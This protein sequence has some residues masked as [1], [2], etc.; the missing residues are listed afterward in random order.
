MNRDLAALGDRELEMALREV[1]RGIE[2]PR[3]ADPWA[4]IERA[5][6]DDTRRPVPLLRRWAAHPVAVAAT[7]ILTAVVAVAAIPET[8]SAVADWLGIGGVRIQFRERLPE[9]GR[10]LALG[11]EV[12]ASVAEERAGFEVR[13]PADSL[14]S[15]DTIFL[16]DDAAGPRV[17][18]VYES[19]PGLPEAGTTGLG[20]LI[21]QLE[22]TPDLPLTKKILDPE[23]G[24][25]Q[26]MVGDT[27]G[28]WVSGDP[29]VIMGY[30]DEEGKLRREWARLAGNTL[31]WT[32][33][34]VTFR[35]ESELS[36]S[37]AVAI[38]ESML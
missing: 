13:V 36:K 9:V 33:D 2:F 6:G 37:E 34:G 11:E 1:G 7:L 35:L 3:F 19:R 20:A 15:P 14:G 12:T 25:E 29:H 22:G 24:V 38:A 18:L 32:S 8:R 23:T 27:A 28:Y 16:A 17:T 10:D 31:L 30:R 26:V 5:L 4:G 21:M